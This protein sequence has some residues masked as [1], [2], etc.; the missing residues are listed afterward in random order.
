MSEIS[1]I[2]ARSILDSR[3]N[4]TIEVDVA[5]HDGAM[6]RA[7]VPSGASTGKN[8][9]LELRDGESDRF[10][11]RGVNRAIDAVLGEIFDLLCGLDVNNQKKIDQ[12]LV[13]L[14]GTP[15]K[16]RLG[17]NAIL[18]VSLAVAHAAAMS[19]GVELFQYIGGV[20]SNL[21]PA[22][23]LNV[24]NGGVHAD[25]PLDIQEF[26]IVPVGFAKF[27]EALRAGAEIFQTLK[28]ILRA[29]NMSVNVGD[30]GGFAPEVEVKT[31]CELLLT[32]IEKA[33]Y[34]AGEDVFLAL[35]L[36][37]SE[38][39]EDGQYQLKGE[40]SVLDS[41]GLVSWLA[42]LTSKYP[43]ISIEDGM[44][45]DDWQ[46]FQQ[47]TQK[48]GSA[49]NLVGDDLFTTDVSRIKRG[50]EEKAANAVL[51]KPNQIGTLSET[52]AALTLAQKAGFDCV[53]SHR[54]GETE[55]TTIADLA[56][57]YRTG[58]IKTGSL[59]RSERTAKYNRLLRI[60]EMLGDGAVYAGLEIRERFIK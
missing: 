50:I 58:W 13:D 52:E 27:S 42:D 23:M 37:A 36:A 3:G 7:A 54:S 56:V 43:I 6:G 2:F 17:A 8:E 60:E 9:A 25:N 34:K 35:D 39:Y 30:E 12:L 21:L 57:G 26:M 47:L 16:S 38:F 31:A 18:G 49:V 53:M 32:A 44:A 46:G 5:L 1:N 14:D 45:E 41:N 10:L 24:I 22:P 28:A 19:N 55:D 20:R 4:P 48:I 33:G 29:Q 40:G 15:N 11:G 51:I 59:A